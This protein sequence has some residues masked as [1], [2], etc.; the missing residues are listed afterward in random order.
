MAAFASATT[1]AL[2]TLAHRMADHLAL[3]LEAISGRAMNKGGFF[4]GLSKGRDCTTAT[5]ERALTWLDG[6]WP[7][8]L[9]WPRDIIARPSGPQ[10]VAPTARELTDISHE[11]IWAN[12]RRP[13][14]WADL[15]V[16]EFLTRA[17]RQMSLLTAAE[18]GA[19]RFGG[20]CPKKSAIHTYW[21]RLDRLH[22]LKT[23]A[24]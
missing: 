5:A 8:D 17:H 1:A 6:F 2:F 4:A 23:E 21:Q 13:L 16:R 19:R 14:W 12:G 15:E 10:L 24:A 11:P 22:E 9:A 3:G 18:I 20:R 7:E